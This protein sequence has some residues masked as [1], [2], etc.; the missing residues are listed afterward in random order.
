MALVESLERMGAI[1]Q[2]ANLRST[3]KECNP[4]WFQPAG[5]TPAYTAPAEAELPP[6]WIRGW[7][8]AQAMARHA[9][10]GFKRCSR[11]EIASRLEVCKACPNLVDNHCA[12]C[13]CACV[14][15]N[16]LINKLALKTEACPL[17]KWT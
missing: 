7:N 10:G 12:L 9:A 13:G 3:L 15:E 4:E 16:Q 14:A 8:F 6:Y 2:A 5:A 1:H 11:R 17:G